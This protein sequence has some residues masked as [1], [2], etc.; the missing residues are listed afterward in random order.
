M[1][2]TNGAANPGRCLHT[3][4]S[5]ISRCCPSPCSMTPLPLRSVKMLYCFNELQPYVSIATWRGTKLTPTQQDEYLAKHP[6]LRQALQIARDTR[7]LIN[8]YVGAVLWYL[9]RE[10]YGAFKATEFMTGLSTGA[11]LQ[12]EDPRLVLRNYLSKMKLDGYPWDGFEQLG[13][14]ITA[15]NAWLR[16]SERY[17]AGSAYKKTDKNFPK[18]TLKKDLPEELFTQEGLVSHTLDE[19]ESAGNR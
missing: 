13:L 14:L 1:H 2:T 7:M 12:I 15:V 6:S 18:L 8:P 10:E 11:N 3:S 19:M 17:K 9:M 5:A 16:K 4:R